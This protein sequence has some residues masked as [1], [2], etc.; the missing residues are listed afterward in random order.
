M[1]TE[2]LNTVDGLDQAISLVDIRG[3]PL[4]ENTM[5]LARLRKLRSTINLSTLDG[6]SSG[7]LGNCM[8]SGLSVSPWNGVR[9]KP[10]CTDIKEQ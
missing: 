5:L 2:D 8:V 4:K 6:A 7:A 1:T 10:I 9:C 3:R